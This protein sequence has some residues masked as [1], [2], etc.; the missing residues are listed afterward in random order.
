M[1]NYVRIAREWHGGDEQPVYELEL[2][3]PDLPEALVAC[4][5]LVSLTF[6]LMDG[7]H[8]KLTLDEDA[9]A[10][11]AF[12]PEDPDGRLYLVLPEDAQE[13]ALAALWTGRGIAPLGELAEQIG[14]RHQ[15][16][17]P[18]LEVQPLGPIVQVEYGA[19]KY[20]DFGADEGAVFHH[21]HEPEN[22][23]LAI[24]AE[25]RLWIVG[26]DYVGSDLRGI[27]G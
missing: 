7:A 1:R 19:K 23:W 27:V 26:G 22:P 25:G 15:G 20:G 6:V 21:E 5:E 14:G 17:Y 10:F 13:D 9:E 16:G 12:D 11:L 4:G 3:D 8:R 24:D 2:E 18:D